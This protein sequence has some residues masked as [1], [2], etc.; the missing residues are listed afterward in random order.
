MAGISD[1]VDY[2][3]GTALKRLHLRQQDDVNMSCMPIRG[4]VYFIQ[5]INGCHCSRSRSF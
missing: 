4:V 2:T 1:E 5:S 3:S